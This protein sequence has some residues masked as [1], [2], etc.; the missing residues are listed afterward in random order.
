MT[1]QTLNRHMCVFVTIL[2]LIIAV[3]GA[4]K[5]AP[6]FGLNKAWIVKLYEFIND[7]SLLIFTIGAA[8]LAN[9]F[10]RRGEFYLQPAG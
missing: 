7:M 9:M 2:L 4:A 1:R 3:A 6:V 8:Y 5:F 10:Q